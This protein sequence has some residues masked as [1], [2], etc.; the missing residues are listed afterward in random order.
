[1]LWSVYLFALGPIVLKLSRR[2]NSLKFPWADA[3]R[4]EG[5]LVA[6]KLINFGSTKRPTYPEYGNSFL[7]KCGKTFSSGHD[8][9]PQKISS[10]G[11]SQQSSNRYTRRVTPQQNNW[12][13]T[14]CV[15]VNR[16]LNI[17]SML[18]A[19]KIPI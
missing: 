17:S 12:M 8:C 16:Q 5:R 6:P 4:Y 9:L 14:L 19:A 2:P 15:C 3:S 10:H 13:F 7:P 18:R 11:R 1:M